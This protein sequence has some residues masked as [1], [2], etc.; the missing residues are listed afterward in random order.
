M[1][2]EKR[3]TVPDDVPLLS[4]KHA[5]GMGA[6][7]ASLYLVDYEQRM[8]RLVNDWDHA[9][10]GHVDVVNFVLNRLVVLSRDLRRFECREDR[11]PHE[12][13]AVHLLMVE[14]A[15]EHDAVEA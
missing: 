13:Q 9:R 11:N 14:S 1:T 6:H 5:R 4:V 3:W 8:L 7:D 2:E 12:P 10:V 15:R